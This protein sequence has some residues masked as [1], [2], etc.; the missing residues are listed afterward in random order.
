MLTSSIAAA[1]A[2]SFSSLDPLGFLFRTWSYKIG[3]VDI[4][5]HDVWERFMWFFRIGLGLVAAAAL[6]LEGRAG[7][8]GE[9]LS[10]RATRRLEWLFVVLGFL[11]YFDFGNPNVR[12]ANYYHRHEFYHYYLGAKYGHA[13]GYTKL[14]DC[15]MVAE[16]DNGRGATVAKREIRD[17][18]VNLI[19]P[20]AEIA[21][22]QNPDQCRSL[23][24]PAEWEDF[25]KDVAW[26]ESTA[27][28]SYWEN[29]QQDH[30][31]NPPPVWTMEGKL[32]ASLAPAGDLF[33]KL[34][35]GI[36]IVFH[37]GILAL[38][39]WGFGP[40]VSA[41]ASVFWGSNAAGNFYWTGGAFLRH[42]WLFLLVA[43]VVLLRKRR[44]GL[45]GAALTYS[46]LLRV[47]PGI[48]L[49]GVAIITAIHLLRHRTL[50]P[51]HRRFIAGCALTLGLLVPASV[52]VTSPEAY[53]EFFSH[54]RVH[55]RTPLTNHMGLET[56]LVHDWSGRM[57]FT[58]DATLDDTFQKW[59]SG[60]LDR[61][62]ARR[63]AFAAISLGVLA[64]MAWALRRTRLLWVGA[65]L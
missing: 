62:A 15:T 61:F 39:A 22:V 55:N 17:L 45:A 26:F 30:G 1:L 37:I 3:T 57:R 4:L 51:A 33:F 60:R 5:S 43:C 49:A 13:L 9:R 47:F 2:S 58:R 25:R 31:Y 12:Y 41:I 20:V 18:T 10:R 28:G 32:V 29:M 40:R 65:S 42:D 19:K 23:F 36:D 63:P 35:A 53:R 48:A 38:L 34:L 56:M 52:A 59:K 14:Y 21:R 7:R 64:W 54:I 44:F 24:T 46:A 50:H 16:I 6:I 11:A 8:L 27:R